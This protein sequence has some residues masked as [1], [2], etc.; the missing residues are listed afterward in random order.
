MDRIF[1]RNAK[2]MRES[3]DEYILRRI[4]E[5]DRKKMQK[6]EMDSI[7]DR[8]EKKIDLLILKLEKEG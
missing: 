1:T 5:E 8:I 4:Q 6:I 2:E 3:R 7:L